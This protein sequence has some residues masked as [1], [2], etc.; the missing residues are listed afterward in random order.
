MSENKPFTV[1]SSSDPD[2][3]EVPEL[4]EDFFE[5]AEI[6][7]GGRLIRPA[8]KTLTGRPIGRPPKGAAAK[9]Q[10][11]VRLSPDVLD[12]FRRD[13]EGWTVRMEA[14]LREYMA[15]H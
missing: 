4:S 13:G 9:E 2:E 1:D 10:V 7:I 5:H 11:T 3:D 14:A 8:T 15:G 6:R 12:F